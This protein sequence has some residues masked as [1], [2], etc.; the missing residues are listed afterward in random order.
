[1]RGEDTLLS[2]EQPSRD[3]DDI[4]DGAQYLH[5]SLNG[6]AVRYLSRI[7]AATCLTFVCRRL[8]ISK[9][10]LD[11]CKPIFSY[12]ARCERAGSDPSCRPYA[13][14]YEFGIAAVLQQA[15]GMQRRAYPDRQLPVPLAATLVRQSEGC[16]QHAMT[17]VV[18]EA[19]TGYLI[20]KNSCT[21]SSRATTILDS[22][23]KASK[24]HQAKQQMGSHCC[25]A[26]VTS[27]F[28]DWRSLVSKGQTMARYDIGLDNWSQEPLNTRLIGYM[29]NGTYVVDS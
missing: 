27:S 20:A 3:L 9:T 22:Q 19:S 25:L 1:M 28:I 4:K 7:Y 8:L 16:Q 29:S 17:G 10:A 26:V 18:S 15:S 2:P 12:R 5:V 11:T 13:V 21:L 14:G 23:H 6:G 24:A